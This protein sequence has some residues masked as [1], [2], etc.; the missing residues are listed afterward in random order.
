MVEASKGPAVGSRPTITEIEK[1]LEAYEGKEVE[2]RGW[3]YGKR[4]SGKIHFLQ[5]RDGTAT[6]QCVMG[7][8]DVDEETFKKAD[9]LPQE[10]SFRVRGVVRRDT[11]SQLGFELSTTGIDVVHVAESYP[12]SPKEHGVAFL[13]DH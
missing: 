7:K 6:L 10:S 5:L 13:M 11:R 3:L 4:S 1:N 12:I 2:L 9:H 8:K